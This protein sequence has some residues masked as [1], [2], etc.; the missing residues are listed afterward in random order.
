MAP[1]RSAWLVPLCLATLYTV[2]GSTYLAQRVALAGF[3][4]LRMAA[5]RFLIAGAVLY[6]PLRLAGA[7]APTRAEWRA[8]VAS[9]LPLTVTGMGVAAL[10][11]RQVPSGLAAL[12]FGS[13]P[14]WA[15]VFDRLWGGRLSR[16]EAAGLALGF[17]GV[18]LVSLRGGLGGDPLGAALVLVAAASYSFG[19][20]ATRRL[21]IPAGALGTAAQMLLGGAVLL[22][23]SV[24][25]GE[26]PSM[27]APRALFAMGYLVVFGSIVSYTAYGYVLRH[28]RPSLST[29]H[30]FVNP[31]VALAL[32]AW[33]GGERFTR[34]DLAGLALVLG[35]V[36][37]VARSR[38]RPAA[39]TP[40]NASS[41][42]SSSSSPQRPLADSS[43]SPWAPVGRSS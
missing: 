2:W 30:A 41:V 23:V 13:V 26:P 3:A 43:A 24:A 5:L 6:V 32:G 22:A 7:P 27:P 4:P 14:L 17:A 12:L 40:A 33:L 16:G 31:I 42:S 11:L 29:S 10:A 18:A 37:L 39:S 35:A 1:R 19:S 15:S 38:P 8:V 34:V 9:T 21:A 20:V 36:A 25:V 28:A